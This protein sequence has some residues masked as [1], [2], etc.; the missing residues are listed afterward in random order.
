MSLPVLGGGRAGVAQARSCH[1]ALAA[2]SPR[3]PT[4]D[5]TRGLR[6]EVLI[7]WLALALLIAI[8]TQENSSIPT[9][10]VASTALRMADSVT[11]QA[12]CAVAPNYPSAALQ[13]TGGGRHSPKSAPRGRPTRH[14]QPV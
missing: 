14:P 7:S 3:A 4:G 9:R 1:R 2:G 12:P 6:P 13:L 5:S 11:G 10:R 8:N